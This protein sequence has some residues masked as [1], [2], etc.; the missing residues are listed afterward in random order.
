[1]ETVI[2]QAFGDIINRNPGGFL[3]RPGVD[4]AFMG[5]APLGAFIKYRIKFGQPV[6]QVI[7]IEDRRL[8][9]PGVPGFP[10]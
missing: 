10:Y 8:G 3:Q 9:L 2:N 4:D 7:G 6:G 1:M 5:D